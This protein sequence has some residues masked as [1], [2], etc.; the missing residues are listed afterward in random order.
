MNTRYISIITKTLTFIG[1][2]LLVIVPMSMVSCEDFFDQESDHVMFDDH[3]H[4]NNATDTI[5]S[6]TGILKKMQVLADRTILLGEARGDLVDITNATSKDLRNVALFDIDD[7]NQYNNPRDYYAVINN[8]NYFLAHV[9]TLLRNSR[10]DTIFKREYAAVKAFR[11]WTYLQLVM[12]YGRVPFVTDPIVTKEEA[13]RMETGNFKEIEEVC[14]WLIQDITPLANDRYLLSNGEHPFY[15]D[16]G[17]KTS[18]MFFYF[19]VKLL[20]G[21]LNLWAGHYKQ[22]AEWYYRYITSRNGDNSTYPTGLNRA[23]WASSEWMNIYNTWSDSWPSNN[24]LEYRADHEII[25]VIP[26][27]SIPRNGNYLQLRNIF[28]STDPV[29]GEYHEVSL[30]PSQGLIDLSAAQVFCLLEGND[31]IY[32][33][34]KVGTSDYLTGDLRLYETFR[35][36]YGYYNNERVETQSIFKYRLANRNAFVWRRQMIWLHMAEAL[37]HA[38]YPRFAYQ[39]LARGLSNQVIREE[40]IPYYTADSLWIKTFDFP[41]TRYVARSTKNEGSGSVN[42]QGLH[43]RGS[44]LAYINAYYQMPFNEEIADSL[45]Q[46]AYQQNE[47]DKMIA[48][49]G[50]LE[51]AFEGLRFYDLVRMALY[52]NEPSF[53][54]DRVYG[55]RGEAKRGEMEGIITKSLNDKYNWFLKWNGKIGY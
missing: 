26:G 9:D 41:D 4:L 15:G 50:A 40:V 43:S 11:A 22:A 19:P 17:Y 23:E 1:Y 54:A 32:A 24:N 13:E 45:E 27:D 28:N 48:D 39:I 44:G 12:N 5:Y 16:I 7:E 51:F 42:M 31:T 8:C 20:L 33:P 49:E 3:E 34:A 6:V 10:N 46:I 35:T 47:L 37:N 29:T 36:S 2:C 53:L 30:V 38:G 21:E 55:R 52:R 14:D 25:T 18:S